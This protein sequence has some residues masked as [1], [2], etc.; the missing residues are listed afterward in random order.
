[1]NVV[2]FLVANSIKSGTLRDLEHA[3]DVTCKCKNYLQNMRLP[4][5]DTLPHLKLL[6]WMR[7]RHGRGMLK[8]NLVGCSVRLGNAT[9]Q[10]NACDGVLVLCLG[11]GA[12]RGGQVAHIFWILNPWALGGR[13]E[14]GCARIGHAHSGM[15]LLHAQ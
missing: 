15:M 6:G 9:L 13:R 10:S 14:Q 1:M 4:P 7:R 3:I 2:N 5:P 11:C 12:T 8:L